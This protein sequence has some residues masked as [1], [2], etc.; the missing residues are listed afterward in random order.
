MVSVRERWLEGWS[1][2]NH[3]SRAAK[4]SQS[5]VLALAERYRSLDPDE[6]GIVD[7]M[8]GAAVLSDEEWRRFDALAL[9]DEFRIASALSSLRMLTRKLETAADPGAPYELKKVHRIMFRL[10]TADK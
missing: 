2:L 4:D 7:E 6:R 3:R 1:E 9:I 10:T 8:L 5:A